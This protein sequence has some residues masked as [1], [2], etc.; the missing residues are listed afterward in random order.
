MLD[1]DGAAHSGSGMIV[2]QAVA[3]AAVTGTPV[4]LRH[5]RA[6]RPNPGLRPQHLC[7]V[8]AVRAMVGGTVDGATVGS[9]E[10][11]FHPA[12]QVPQGRYQFDV[13]TAGSAAALSLALLPVAATACGPVTLDLT[14][15][16]FQ[17]RAPSALHLQHVLA[18]LLARM[19][20]AVTVTLLRPGYAPTGGGHLRL[21]VHR[22]RPL[23]ALTADQ[24]GRVRSIWGISLASHL[25]ARHVSRRMAEAARAVLA[26]AGFDA[27]IEER[28]DT[29][30]RQPGAGLALFA[31]L[32]DGYRLGADHAGAR[33]RAAEAIGSTAAKQLL[34]DLRTGAA[35][36][37]HAG[38]QVL[39]FVA[40][41]H[42]QSRALL[43]ALTDHVHTGVWLTGLF[44][45][46]AARL[47]GRLLVVDGGRVGQVGDDLCS[48]PAPADQRRGA[49]RAVVRR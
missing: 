43:A 5:V 17:D 3:Y 28:D 12:G 16:L 36:D 49:P 33:G 14:G 21:R 11:T 9:R 44:D 6:L 24:P 22:Q 35:L 40:L 8:E 19:G 46:A 41:A 47:D 38:D 42:G 30:A 26:Q 13:G 20:L 32:A 29:A 39:P 18:P 4:H 1:I 27:S 37:R 48:T 23:T 25:R 7:A 15:G 45:L 2:R 31:D 10:F 34:E